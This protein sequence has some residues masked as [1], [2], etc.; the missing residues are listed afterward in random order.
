MT[1]ILFN[2]WVPPT[3]IKE[4]DFVNVAQSFEILN[5]RVGHGRRACNFRRKPRRTQHLPC[6]S[7]RMT[8]PTSYDNAVIWSNV[9]YWLQ[10]LFSRKFAAKSV[11]IELSYQVDM[12]LYFI[13]TCLGCFGKCIHNIFRELSLTHCV[14]KKKNCLCTGTVSNETWIII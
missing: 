7:Y 8:L 14:S 3:P 12:R 10:S 9:S 6:I 5:A 13:H 4:D 11:S 2:P 1:F